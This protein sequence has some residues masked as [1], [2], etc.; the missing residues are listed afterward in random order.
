MIASQEVP[1][2][3]L[4][5]VSDDPFV[6]HQID[7]R[8]V[9]RV[10][11]RG[12]AAVVQGGRHRSRI[13]ALTGGTG[14]A[15][16]CLGPR[17]DL[18]PLM[19][20]V[21]GVLG[22]PPGRVTM[23]QAVGDATP[24]RWHC[25]RVRCWDWM[26]TRTAPPAAPA[27]PTV[28]VHDPDEIDAVLDAANPDSFGRPGAPGIDRWLGVRLDGTLV[29]VGALERMADGTGHLR[30][31]SVLPEVRGRGVGTAISLGLT[32]DALKD[33]SGVAT[34]GAY[35]DNTAALAIYSRLGYRTAHRFRSGAVATAQSSG[36][37]SSSRASTKAS[38]P[39]R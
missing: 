22:A 1:A 14:P 24:L 11:L 26:W 6:R 25:P 38:E 37:P 32:A 12:D 34:L 36:G 33:G 23:E 19:R 4:F 29:G 16:T 13:P 10:W 30:G 39:S 35:S 9:E 18:V 7:R 28:E 15:L 27:L 5:A 8:T 20:H 3:E 17:R 21:D 31:V 2:E